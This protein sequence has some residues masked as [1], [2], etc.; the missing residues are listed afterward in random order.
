MKET[1]RKHAIRAIGIARTEVMSELANAIEKHPLWPTDMI[2]QW[3]IVQEEAGEVQKEV[4]QLMYETS[5]AE[6]PDKL[7]RIR[8]EAIQTTAM[9]LRFLAHLEMD[10]IVVKPSDEEQP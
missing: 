3:A 9:C 4:L 5:A 1:E 10:R 7:T 8:K 2:H 6:T